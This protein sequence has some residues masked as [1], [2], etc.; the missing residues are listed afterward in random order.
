MVFF[1]RTPQYF[2]YIRLS[3]KPTTVAIY[4][5]SGTRYGALTNADGFYSIN[6]MHRGG[7]YIIRG[8]FHRLWKD[9]SFRDLYFPR[10]GI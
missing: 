3:R 2:I 10:R 4:V 9:K 7:P 1:G 6:G 5:P 8:I